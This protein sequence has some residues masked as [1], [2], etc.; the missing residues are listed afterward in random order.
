MVLFLAK[1][2]ILTAICIRRSHKVDGAIGFF[3]VQCRRELLLYTLNLS[4][5][6]VD[7]VYEQL[8]ASG[9]IRLHGIE[10]ISLYR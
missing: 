2:R 9:D 7:L 4:E 10:G 5:N 8:S 3:A 6:D 1:R